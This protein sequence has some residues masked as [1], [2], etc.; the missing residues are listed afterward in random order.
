MRH[1]K[2]G[3]IVVVLVFTAMNVWAIDYPKATN[4]VNDYAGVLSGEEEQTLNVILKDFDSQTST[5]IFVAILDRVP[6]DSTL[7]E[8]VNELF[9]RWNP[10]TKGQDTGALL[11]I[12]VK[13]RQLRIEVGY[14]LEDR[15]TDAASKLIITNDIAPSF[16]QEA[17]YTGIRNGLQ[18]M[19]QIIA[20]DYQFPTVSRP[21]ATRPQPQ[22][23]LDFL[24]FLVIVV[25]VLVAIV[26]S[27]LRGPRAGWQS[28]R[29]GWQ[30]RRTRS[31]AVDVGFVLLHILIEILF[32]GGGS[33]R[34]GGSSG[35][36]GGFSGGRGGSSG[37]GGA[38]GGW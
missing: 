35:G 6:S 14:G 5:Q 15:L 21:P 12:F 19:T 8:Y 24:F 11:A 25:I 18:K 4:W 26:G 30:R 22:S 3:M 1:W 31:V 27:V 7:E 37:G 9:T 17:Y 34:S 10:G 29:S 16:R 36:F 32:S 33:R 38:S 23:N 20:P 13:D 2:R 28:S